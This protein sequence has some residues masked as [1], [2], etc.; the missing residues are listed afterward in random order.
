V[1]K[2]TRNASETRE[3]TSWQVGTLARGNKF[4]VGRVLGGNFLT[5]SIRIGLIYYGF[6]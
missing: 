6:I 2:V 4:R 3:G 5:K 1:G